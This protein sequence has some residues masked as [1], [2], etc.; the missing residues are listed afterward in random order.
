MCQLIVEFGVGVAVLVRCFVDRKDTENQIVERLGVGFS[1]PPFA[2]I[3]VRTCLI[4]LMI[5]SCMFLYMSTFPLLVNG[6]SGICSVVHYDNQK[7]T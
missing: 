6:I 4:Y 1:R 7:F 3:V 2:T 5:F